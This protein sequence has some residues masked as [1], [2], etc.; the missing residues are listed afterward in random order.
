MR[1]GLSALCALALGC[2]TLEF[3]EGA[4][5]AETVAVATGR[6]VLALSTLGISEGVFDRRDCYRTMDLWIG[7]NV[8]RAFDRIGPPLRTRPWGSKYTVYGWSRSGR[9]PY[10]PR[11]SGRPAAR[12]VPRDARQGVQPNRA[13]DGGGGGMGEFAAGFDLDF[14]FQLIADEQSIVR[15]WSGTCRLEHFGP[16]VESLTPDPEADQS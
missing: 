15:S 1:C 3:R 14:D 5:G 7:M 12:E 9:E 10:V 6:V 2:S 16:G 11:T 13:I 4:G 8:N